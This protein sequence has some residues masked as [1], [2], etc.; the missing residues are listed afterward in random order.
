MEC[1]EQYATECDG[2]YATK[3]CESNAFRK[4]ENFVYI[5]TGKV[6]F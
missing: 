4:I 2:Q 6:F 3:G 1:C 5:K